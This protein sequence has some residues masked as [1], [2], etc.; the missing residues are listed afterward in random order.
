MF[1][2]LDITFLSIYDASGNLV[3]GKMRKDGELIRSDSIPK[4]VEVKQTIYPTSGLFASEEGVQYVSIG[5]ITNASKNNVIAGFLVMGWSID[6][7][8]FEELS[9]QLNIPIEFEENIA[10]AILGEKVD[11]NTFY[12][13]DENGSD[14]IVT[15]K[16]SSYYGEEIFRLK[17]TSKR[18]LAAQ[19]NTIRFRL[20]VLSVITSAIL[21]FLAHA[22]H[23]R[24]ISRPLNQLIE[25]INNLETYTPDKLEKLMKKMMKLVC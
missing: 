18:F 11:D 23:N 4:Q 3:Y 12:V 5:E 2:I 24:W 19:T 13:F 9:K 7:S 17:T 21:I 25:V 8:F 22:F 16:I 20:V 10:D 1:D 6:E 15:R 14:V